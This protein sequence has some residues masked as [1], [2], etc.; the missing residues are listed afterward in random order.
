MTFHEGAIYRAPNG[1]RYRAKLEFP[2]LDIIP[3][4]TFV[5]VD[6]E[7]SEIGSWR[8]TLSH[9]LFLEKGKIVFFHFEAYGPS[10]RETGWREVDFV[11]E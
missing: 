6:F 1:K 4:W 5:P 11:P 8:D 10:I 2:R 3:A 9:L 7:D